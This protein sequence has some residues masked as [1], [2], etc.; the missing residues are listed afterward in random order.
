VYL[1]A[2]HDEVT[3]LIEEREDGISLYSVT[4]EM[5]GDTWHFTVDEAKA[6]ASY[7]LGLVSGPWRPV[8][9]DF[10]NRLRTGITTR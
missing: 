6:Q 2:Q 5:V 3:F 10:G 8:D 1:L 7:T 4:R 9:D